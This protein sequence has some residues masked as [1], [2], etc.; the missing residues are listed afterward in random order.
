MA[1]D[2]PALRQEAEAVLRKVL[3]PAAPA[4]DTLAMVNTESH[5]ARAM[6]TL[7][8]RAPQWLTEAFEEID[9]VQRWAQLRADIIQR[10]IRRHSPVQYPDNV[11]YC[12]ECK[13]T[14]PCPTRQDVAQNHSP[15]EPPR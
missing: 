10:V 11:W 15:K 12:A 6:A 14:Y 4:E 2:F 3:A 1:K 13:V 5:R 7:D 8:C 9:R